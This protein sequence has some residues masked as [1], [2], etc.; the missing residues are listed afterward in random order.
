MNYMRNLIITGLLLF[1]GIFVPKFFNQ[2]WKPS[3]HGLTHTDVALFN[4]FVNTVFSPPTMM[5]LT[6]AVILDNTIE[7]EKSKKDRGMPW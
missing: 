7:V 4:A 6:V 1:L 5:G 3:H 2:Y